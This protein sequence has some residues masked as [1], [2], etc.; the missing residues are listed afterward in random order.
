MKCVCPKCSVDVNIDEPVN[1]E[2]G[3]FGRCPECSSRF[4]LHRETFLLRGYKKDWMAFCNHC[5]DEVGPASYCQSCYSSFPDYWVVQLSKP[6]RRKTSFN[7]GFSITLPTKKTK[8]CGAVEELSD[9]GS[10]EK[11]STPIKPILIAVAALV[12]VIG[13][14]MGGMQ[15]YEGH[16]RNLSFTNN[17]FKALYGIKSGADFNLKKIARIASGKPLSNK[18]T[19]RLEEIRIKIKNYRQKLATPPGRFVKTVADLDGVYRVY[20]D[21]HSLT[22]S[23]VGMS[24]EF[25][26]K[27]ELMKSRLDKA[28]QKLK[29]GFPE[30]LQEDAREVAGKYRNLQF[31][32]E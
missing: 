2:K 24:E 1:P 20:V 28:E 16:E 8:Q 10:L 29:K 12:I 26:G 32:I 11:V 30:E 9:F 27:V 25:R 22:L 13:I 21:L 15:L 7:T 14:V 31:L 3:G 17:Y 23:T 4:W 6:S 18:E 5:G 19:A